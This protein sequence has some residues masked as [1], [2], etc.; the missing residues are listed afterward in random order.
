MKHLVNGEFLSLAEI[1]REYDIPLSTIYQRNYRGWK[2]N[3]LVYPR[4]KT[5]KTRSVMFQG[6]ET[7]IKDL[8]KMSGLNEETITARANKG[9]TGEMLIRPRY[10]RPGKEILWLG[11]KWTLKEFTQRFTNYHLSTVCHKINKGE[12][13]DKIIQDSENRRKD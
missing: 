9:D 2:G 5:R 7:S 4:N 6:V 12:S 1:S 8:A 3:E 10:S 11:Q 13:P